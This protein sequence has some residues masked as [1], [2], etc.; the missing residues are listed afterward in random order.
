MQIQLPCGNKVDT[1]KIIKKEN[2]IYLA[3]SEQRGMQQAWK[4]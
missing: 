2:N 4:L 3:V 1:A